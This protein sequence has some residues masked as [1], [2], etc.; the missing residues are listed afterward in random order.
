M[1]V[2]TVSAERGGSERSKAAR[3]SRKSLAPRKTQACVR[4]GKCVGV[5]KAGR[6]HC[7]H[8]TAAGWS[9]EALPVPGSC[10]ARLRLLACGVSRAATEIVSALP[11]GS[12][13]PS[14]RAPVLFGDTGDTA[15]RTAGRQCKK[16]RL[17]RQARLCER[18][19]FSYHLCL[20]RVLFLTR[21]TFRK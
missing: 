14:S 15:W 3:A 10:P 16:L 21:C 11:C 6:G 18:F 17:W 8:T 2:A 1:T 19:I 12:Q 13:V 20:L 4:P 7:C 5:F 9:S